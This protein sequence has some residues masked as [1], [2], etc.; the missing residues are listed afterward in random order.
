MRAEELPLQVQGALVTAEAA[1]VAEEVLGLT[2]L[3]R[4]PGRPRRQQVGVGVPEPDPKALGYVPLRRGSVAPCQGLCRGP[5]MVAG[6]EVAAEHQ[7]GQR[8]HYRR[9]RV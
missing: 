6:P 8:D 4:H 1:A 3:P 9:E 7:D 5:V 2:V